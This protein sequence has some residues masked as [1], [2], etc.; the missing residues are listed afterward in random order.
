MPVNGS[1]RRFAPVSIALAC[2]LPNSQTKNL[3]TDRDVRP[4]ARFLVRS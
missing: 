4:T 2:L 3:V 1:T